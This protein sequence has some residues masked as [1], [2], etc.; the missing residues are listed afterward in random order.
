MK[1]ELIQKLNSIKVEHR[2]CF[3]IE[4]IPQMITQERIIQN[5]IVLTPEL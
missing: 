5:I 4:I 3:D 2:Y 1:A